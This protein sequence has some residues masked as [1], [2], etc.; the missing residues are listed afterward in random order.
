MSESKTMTEPGLSER[1]GSRALLQ[2]MLC[3]MITRY[4]TEDAR[5]IR[6]DD[7]TQERDVHGDYL[8]YFVVEMG[9][10]ARLKVSVDVVG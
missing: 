5:P 6:I 10:G 7:V 1:L 8:P 4:L 2:G 9:S 3:G